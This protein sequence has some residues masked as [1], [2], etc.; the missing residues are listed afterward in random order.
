M[1]GSQVTF[2]VLTE[3]DQPA[4]E[5]TAT[6]GERP[7]QPNQAARFWAEDLGFAVRDM[8]FED[9]YDRKLP[10]D[11][12][13]VVVAI[14]KPSSAAQSARLQNNDLITRLNQGAVSDVGQFKKQYEDFRKASPRESIV[15]EVLRGVNTQVIRIEPPQ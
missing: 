14:V 6:L 3:K 8:V 15:L 1:P 7:R 9:S 2:T 11:T 12:K 4:K 10:P 13:G 5:I